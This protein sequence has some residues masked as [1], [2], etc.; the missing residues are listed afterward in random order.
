V[1]DEAQ[2]APTEEGLEPAGP[3]WFVVNAREAVWW[4]NESFGRWC[5]FEGKADG[6]GFEQFGINV[7]VVMPGQP[8]A[9]YHAEQAQEGFL[10]LAGEC[11]LLVEGEERRLRAWD[12]FHCP[13]G[14]EHVIVG[15][16]DGPCAVLMVGARG[17]PEELRYPAAEVA[18][19]HHAG[20]ETETTDAD[21]AYAKYPGSERTQM[22]SDVPIG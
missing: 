13:A 20:V 21:V 7:H 9:L 17:A 16:G 14:T 19:R 15:A 11:L 6:A 4:R 3:G 18:L 5:V 1:I 22:P 12:F 2:L 10:V 8:N